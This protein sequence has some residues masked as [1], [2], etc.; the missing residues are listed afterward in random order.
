MPDRGARAS[1]TVRR[2]PAWRM[3][4]AEADQLLK[5]GAEH[6]RSNARRF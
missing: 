1:G 6:R 5:E 4:D 2:A 3:G